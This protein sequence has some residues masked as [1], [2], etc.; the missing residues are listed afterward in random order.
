MI[1]MLFYIYVSVSFFERNCGSNL[2]FDLVAVVSDS[3]ASLRLQIYSL[4]I[5]T[6][7]C[8]IY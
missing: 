5:N 8:F 2:S 4:Y 6:F 7:L 3:S 1:T